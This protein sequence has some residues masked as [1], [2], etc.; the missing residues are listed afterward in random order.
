M[1]L[2]D[3]ALQ[4]SVISDNEHKAGMYFR[5]LRY[6]L[7]GKALVT[8]KQ[9][10]INYGAEIYDD[11]SIEK[12]YILYNRSLDALKRVKA[13]DDIMNIC[14]YNIVPKY[15]DLE[16]LRNGLKEL[17]KLYEFDDKNTELWSNHMYSSGGIESLPRLNI[18]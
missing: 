11:I 16:N 1:E 10:D 18:V 7:F 6:R 9:Y 14:I 8:A 4:K 13:L 2:L 12:I 5:I 15:G 3:V 17:L